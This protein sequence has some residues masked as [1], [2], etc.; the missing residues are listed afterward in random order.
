MCLK[1]LLLY[2]VKGII[3]PKIKILGP[4]HFILSGLKYYVVTSKNKYNVLLFLLYCKTL[5]L[6][7]R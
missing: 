7:L 5:L 3:H 2:W 1:P 6:L 4:T